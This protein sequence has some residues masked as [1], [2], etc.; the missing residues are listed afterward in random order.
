MMMIFVCF[1]D[2]FWKLITCPENTYIIYDNIIIVI[3]FYPKAIFRVYDFK[4]PATL[5]TGQMLFSIILIYLVSTI[6][7]NRKNTNSGGSYLNDDHHEGVK[8]KLILSS[9]S[10]VKI[11]RLNK[12]IFFRVGPLSALFLLKLILDMSALSLINMYVCQ[13][14]TFDTYILYVYVCIL[15]TLLL[16]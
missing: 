16:I 9:K 14:R 7:N 15:C 3:I 10:P 13:L 6:Q 8:E 2:D 5:V 4:A 12:K 1:L 11:Q